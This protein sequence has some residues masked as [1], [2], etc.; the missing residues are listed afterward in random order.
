MIP[1]KYVTKGLVRRKGRTILT[2]AS[3][4][5]V[6]AVFAAMNAVT[7]A[8]VNS[9]KSTGLPDEIVIMERGAMTVDL[10]RI[11]RGTLSY[12][13]TLPGVMIEDNKPLVSPEMCI[14]TNVLIQGRKVELSI[15]G[16]TPIAR[17]V[18]RQTKVV[19]GDWPSQGKK[20]AV[21]QAIANKYDMVV[22]D[23]VTFQEES[24]TVT[25]ILGGEGTVYDQE[26]W[27]DLD[28]VA[29]VSHR[30]TF[31]NYAIRLR[32]PADADILVK[33]INSTQRYPLLAMKAATF[34]SQSGAMAIFLA[35]IGSFIS[36]I[37]AIGAIFG[38]MNTM[39][40]HTAARRR[41]IAI[42]KAIGFKAKAILGAFVV[43]SIMLGLAGGVFGLAFASGI[44]LV[45]VDLPYLPAGNVT[46]G[47]AQVSS[48]LIM[49]VFV[50][51]LGGLLP[52]I[53]AARLVVVKEIRK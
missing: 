12:V 18:Y 30:K 4:A 27:A 5:S 14:G 50:G 36:F 29:A 2:V 1:M 24:W 16:V 7:Q 19:A 32:T 15:R 37:M 40:S 43:E 3:V 25:G 46:L 51:L 45:P 38:V 48:A 11:Q 23:S 35:G 47:G 42:M 41:E 13:Q 49:G 17:D 8:M 31:S 39:Y 20:V 34:Y 52:S 22:G 21:G 33:K 28:E 10:S 9:F 26:I 44:A 6:I 53:Q